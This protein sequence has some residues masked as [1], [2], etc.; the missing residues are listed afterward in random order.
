MRSK[1]IFFLCWFI[2]ICGICRAEDFG[3][4]EFEQ[5]LSEGRS[6]HISDGFA[7]VN[8]FLISLYKNIDAFFVRPF[9]IGYR[10]LT[11]H[12]LREGVEN[13]FNF[14]SG[15]LYLPNSLLVF[16]APNF[17]MNTGYLLATF[18]LGGGFSRIARDFD[19]KENQ[20]KFSSLLRFYY[21]PELFYLTLGPLSMTFPDIL[22]LI[23][24]G[25]I[26]D[27]FL[28]SFFFTILS[29]GALINLRTENLEAMDA[30]LML[31]SFSIYE[32]LKTQKYME[33]KNFH[34]ERYLLKQEGKFL[35][36]EIEYSRNGNFL[37]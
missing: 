27:I 15:I 18:T 7:P 4:D 5:R 12:I 14:A 2:L 32:N 23:A 36:K 33:A 11:P 13:S 34:I 17:I 30:V 28:P 1:I 22:A 9:S 25:I 24:T 8:I 16:N 37:Q 29:A 20:I 26:T 21:T 3:E 31:S 6:I 10:A 35:Q 19:L